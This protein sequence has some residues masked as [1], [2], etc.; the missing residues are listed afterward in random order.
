MSSFLISSPPLNVPLLQ[1][2]LL[3]SLLAPLPDAYS[4]LDT[5]R[6][7]LVHFCVQSL[8]IVKGIDKLGDKN[9]QEIV[10][11]IYNLQVRGRRFG[12]CEPIRVPDAPFS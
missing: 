12:A 11:W 8:A 6:L 10:N 9:V 5:N 7:T 2:Y 1:K 4:S 3:H